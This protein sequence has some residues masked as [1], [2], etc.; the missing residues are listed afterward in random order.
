[1]ADLMRTSSCHSVKSDKG[2]LIN[3]VLNPNN[4]LLD[5]KSDKFSSKS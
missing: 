2:E 5:P 3:P 1:M 4:P